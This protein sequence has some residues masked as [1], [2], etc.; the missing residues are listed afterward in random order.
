MS[1]KDWAKII[2][3]E[4][5]MGEKWDALSIFE[6]RKMLYASSVNLEFA[7]MSWEDITK[8][9]SLYGFMIISYNA[10]GREWVINDSHVISR[11]EYN[12]RLGREIPKDIEKVEVCK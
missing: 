2:I 6:R 5:S 12:R 1:L 10:S 4:P 9:E 3:K 8:D 11:R 7:N